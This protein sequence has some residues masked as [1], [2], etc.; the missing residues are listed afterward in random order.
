M[1]QHSNQFRQRASAALHDTDLQTNMHHLAKLL[2]TLRDTAF[3]KMGNESELRNFVQAMKDHTLANL[4]YYLQQFEQQFTNNGGTLHWAKNPDELNSI[5]TRICR[6]NNARTVLKGKS[7]VSEECAL[8]EALEAA[9]LDVTETDLGEYIIQLAQEPPSHIVGPAI[10]KT[11]GDI[12]ELFETHHDLGERSLETPAQMVAEART[13]LRKR[14]LAGDV[15]ITGANALIAETG[16]VMLVTN[17]GNGDLSANLPPVHIVV[18]TLDR[19]VPR[20]EDATATLRL[21]VRSATGQSITAYTSFYSGPGIGQHS[22]PTQYH[23]VLLDNKRSELLGGPYQDMLRCIRC[24]SCI[25]HCPVYTAVGG[26]SFGWVY[27]GPMGSVLTPLLTGLEQANALPHACTSCGRCAEVCPSNIP[28][29]DLLRDLREEEAKKQLGSTRWRL[30]LKAHSQLLN[31]PR[32]YKALTS[33][34]IRFLS[35]LSM[36]KASFRSLPFAKSWTSERDFP[37]PQGKTFF[38]QYQQTSGARH[39]Q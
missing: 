31:H 14:F 9:G 22:E 15:G 29:P 35:W 34:A 11:L 33:V 19:L 36:G 5:V 26:H 23:L 1:K 28:I 30:G 20:P 27:P 24:A 10:H 16:N 37:A 39:E 2:P 13:V 21:L 17:E 4:D 38:S 8:S 25:N 12:R 18:T 6:D 32:L 3:E 7:M